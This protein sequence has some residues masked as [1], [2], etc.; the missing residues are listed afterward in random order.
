MSG[1]EAR[2]AAL[3]PRQRALL[4]RRLD[5]SVS[6]QAADGKPE[7]SEGL[8]AYV[9]SKDLSTTELQRYLKERLPD[10]MVPRTCVFLDAIP[11][12]SSGKVDKNS[13]SDAE[14]T[15]RLAGDPPE[16]PLGDVES[17]LAR[18]WAQVLGFDEV[19]RHDDFF[20][21]GGDSLL[22]IRAIARLRQAGLVVTPKQFFDNPTVAG[23]A[24]VATPVM[25]PSKTAP[26]HGEGDE[27]PLTPFQQAVFEQDSPEECIETHAFVL[28]VPA[29]LESA[30]VKDALGYVVSRHDALRLRWTRRDSGWR[31]HVREL[32]E[33]PA[34]RVVDLSKLSARERPGSIAREASD[35]QAAFKLENRLPIDATFFHIEG[36]ASR[37]LLIA[38]SLSVDRESWRVL[39][40]SMQTVL[41]QLVRKQPAALPESSTF[42]RWAEALAERA[43]STE[44]GE[45]AGHWLAL[46]RVTDYAIPVDSPDRRVK[47]PARSSDS[48]SVALEEHETLWLLE[49]APLAYNVSVEDMIVTALAQSLVIWTGRPYVLLDLER[50][51]REA[52]QEDADTQNRVGCFTTRF[53]AYLEI[54]PDALPGDALKSIKEQL[55]A[56]PNMGVGYGLLRFLR[57]DPELRARLQ[58][59]PRS[60]VRF[61]FLEEVAGGKAQRITSQNMVTRSHREPS[62]SI[63]IEAFVEGGIFGTV[64]TYDVATH[65]ADS[66]RR[67]ASDFVAIL[68][69]LIA[70]CRSEGAG[71]YTPSDFPLADVDQLELDHIARL[72]D[73][74]SN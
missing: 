9:V 70:H 37:L 12:T 17:R 52:V 42:R 6:L 2:I 35:L 21:M 62:H 74:D 61:R 13:L 55:R 39:L 5:D 72:L 57:A 53:P 7:H 31:Q 68:R 27:V 71:G 46:G 47:N 3:T 24:A 63:Q 38:S 32:D 49:E 19:A 65:E 25:P 14:A 8:V 26:A 51:G 4:S 16:T 1:I 69:K 44:L 64:W 15:A 54:S 59:L 73:D 40:E 22:S 56:I 34:L 43:Q 33:P 45:E 50:D 28:D 48:I 29:E 67:R 58:A 66:I 10:Y 18:I 23:L 41:A 60:N 30:L 11:L 36:E 20:E